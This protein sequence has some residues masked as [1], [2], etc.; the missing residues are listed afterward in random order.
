MRQ[1][2]KQNLLYLLLAGIIVAATFFIFYF[3]KMFRKPTDYIIV[4]ND[5]ITKY[6]NV[7]AYVIR[8]EKVINTDSYA[9][10][11]KVVA[12]DA[13]KIAKGGVIASF[14]EE[15]NENVKRDISIIDEQIQELIEEDTTDYSQELKSVD[16]ELGQMVYDIYKSENE[17]VSLVTLK[18]TID[19]TLFNKIKNIGKVVPDNSELKKL[20]NER[21]GYENSKYSSK[22][23]LKS[24][25]SGMI[26]YRVDG[27]ESVLTPDSFSQITINDLKRIPFVVDQQ[28]P[29][30]PNKIK[31][32]N[33]FSVYLAILTNSEESKTLSV[34]DTIRISFDGTFKTYSKAVVEYI[35]E[36]DDTRIVIVKTE[37]NTEDLSKYR[38]IN[39]DIIWWNYEGMKVP[40][41]SIYEKA[42]V[43][44]N[45]GDLY[46]KVQAIKV[47]GTTGYQKEV[48][49]NV[50]KS[51]SDFSIIKNY[52]D[53]EL[54][55]MGIPE[56]I[57]DDRNKVNLYDRVIIN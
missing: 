32:V 47:L 8:D 14:I 53:D 16:K 37:D 33:N 51:T 4:R 26:S 3:I 9:G 40:N 42:I 20:I 24:D 7:T 18:E 28:I 44:E 23:D 57:V 17:Y 38:K 19:E 52:E 45:T 35:A 55:E 56:A 41:E 30:D 34:N 5:R 50:E 13:T 31:I 27:Y 1:T 43:D 15:E 54:M 11:R 48:Y 39:L 6:E 49:I 25:E 12:Q 21:I 10:E 22:N 29:I 46:A 2:T 36:E